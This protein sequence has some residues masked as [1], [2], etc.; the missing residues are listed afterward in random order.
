[1]SSIP[2]HAP[3]ATSQLAANPLPPLLHTPAGLA[4]LEIQGSLHTP[5][6]SG[7]AGMTDIGKLVFPLY[8]PEAPVADLSWSKSPSRN[9][10]FYVCFL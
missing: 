7:E 6:P 9:H 1:M 5:H 3:A 10:T 8:D 4:I 2:L